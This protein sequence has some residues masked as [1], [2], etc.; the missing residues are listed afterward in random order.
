[1]TGLALIL[2][3][4]I[5]A[6]WLAWRLRL[7]SILLLL[8][9]GFLAGPV[10]HLVLPDQLFGELLLPLV[11]LFVALILFEGGM[12]LRIAEL[13]QVGSVVRALCTSGALVTGFIA[14]LAARYVLR[15]DWHLATLLG[16][17]L[18]VTGPTV[19]G[20]LLRHVKPV[21]QVGPILRWEGIVID[22][23]GALLSVLVFE[24]IHVVGAAASVKG[25]TTLFLMGAIKTA[26]VGCAVGALAALMLVLLLAR[27]YVPDHLQNPVSLATVAA[28]FV[29]SNKLQP[30][31]GLFTV[32]VMGILV[33]NQKRVGVHHIA[34][35]KETLSVLLIS[36]LFIILGARLQ[37]DQITR[38]GPRGV[39]FLAVLI[40]IARPLCV[41][42]ST[43]GS[44]L[45]WR[46]RGF[47][48]AMAPRGIVAAAVSSV[49]ALRL[50]QAGVEGADL[51]VPYTF[52]VIIGT[53]IVYGLA[54]TPI[55][56]RLK[57]R[58]TSVQGA[59]IVGANPLARA[60][61][62]ALRDAGHPVLLVDTNRGEI[63][64]ARLEGFTV[65]PGSI[66]SPDLPEQLELGGIG[67]LFALTANDE[68]N[69]LAA[70]RFARVFGR[71]EVY[72]LAPA[73]TR[74][75]A[76]VAHELRGRPLFDGTATFDALSQR[77][78]AGQQIKTTNLTETFD[79]AAY[80]QTHPEALPLFLI[81]PGGAL[82]VSTGDLAA[83][84]PLPGM[85]IVSLA[86]PVVRQAESAKVEPQMNADGRG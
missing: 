37:L 26:G 36:S 5:G 85:S 76:E 81:G 2:V 83:S 13:K 78:A 31:S 50:R 57:L 73:A 65:H 3:L 19:I 71:A 62:K 80:R 84:A 58:P 66:L 77:L 64:Q 33:A 63:Q 4:G 7:P 82:T 34:E 8:L 6:Q 39:L 25:V 27:F 44:S 52:V 86:P 9:F 54:A 12:S 49:F 17:I 28:A 60:I 10:T 45:N 41:L 61:G 46:E 29:A 38:A 70:L 67:K 68:V 32:T 40:L 18:L 35:F 30:E 79:A 53:V 69:S 48:M 59:L 14:A 42:A 72:Q 43:A 16:S 1:M 11:S 21:G 20:P 15:L 23:I 24:T 22:P 51:L 75:S 47:L 74:K 55:A 56:K